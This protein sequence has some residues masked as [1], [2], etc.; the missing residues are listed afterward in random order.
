MTTE[1]LSLGVA[2]ADR[3]VDLWAVEI[4]QQTQIGQGTIAGAGRSDSGSAVIKRNK[5]K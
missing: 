2:N 5:T 4:S 3:F 1:E